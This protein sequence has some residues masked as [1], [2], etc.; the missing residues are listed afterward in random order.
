MILSSK[1]RLDKLAEDSAKRALIGSGVSVAG[2]LLQRNAGKNLY[3]LHKGTKYDADDE[4]V[5]KVISRYI[6]A[7][8]DTKTYKDQKDP[9]NSYYNPLDN[10]IHTGKDVTIQS[11]ETGHA[12]NS[13]K[14]T[15]KGKV[16]AYGY[17]ISKTMMDNAGI[18]QLMTANPGVLLNPIH[19][20]SMMTGYMRA[21]K[22]K[23][24]KSGLLLKSSPE[25]ITAIATSPT[26]YEEF[27][28]SKNGLKLLDKYRTK[29]DP[30]RRKRDKQ[31]LKEAWKTYGYSA[32]SAA[33]TARLA[34]EAGY[35]M[36]LKAK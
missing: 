11:H 31:L 18:D 16:R 9:L 2:I 30:E 33:G 4:R 10:T 27:K 12:I 1:K 25:L 8:A 23:K 28:A 17:G 13:R 6:K 34:H 26:L 36:G 29:K 22:D 35:Q 14:G 21:Q 24:G 7:E 5:S 19:I 15:I 20:G 32:L 3:R